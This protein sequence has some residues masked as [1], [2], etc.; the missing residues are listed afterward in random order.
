MRRVAW[1]AALCV[2]VAVR[3]SAARDPATRSLI[4]G[5][6]WKQARAILEPRVQAN[7]SDAEAA[8]LL[9][10]VREAFG[11]L[12]AALPLAETAVRLEPGV[13]DYHW[14]LAEVVGQQARRASVLRQVGLARRFRQEAE[15]TMKLD[16]AHIEARG[17]MI[18]FY[19][20]APRV[21]GGDRKR[22]DQV[23]EEVT[24]IDPAWGYLARARVLTEAQASADVEALYRQAADAARAPA[25]K[26]QAT[27][28]LLNA[29]LTAKPAKLEAAEQAARSLLTID[30]RR[31]AGYVGLAIVYAWSNR[32]A[33]LEATLAESE[34]NVA[35][36]FAPFYQAARVLLTQ[37]SDLTRAERYL[38]K[39]LTIE[40][41]AG[42]PGHAQ[43]H[44]RL[45]LVLEKQGKKTEAIAAIEQAIKLNPDFDEAK[46]DLKRLR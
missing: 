2:L 12:D 46:K 30:P 40:P 1:S 27:A 10:R 31:A 17:G 23:A 13:A 41:E 24:R 11:N 37:G 4:D 15:T 21:V 38:R 25:V 33:E 34:K 42:T 16:P 3:A 36:D 9:S 45:G 29:L 7:P 14:R 8:A 6:H 44:W 22:A 18:S 32:P 20:Q 43:A 28:S 39:Y 26:F 5:G 35:D 19:V